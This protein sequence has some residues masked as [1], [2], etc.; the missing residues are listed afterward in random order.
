MSDMSDFIGVPQVQKK[1][2]RQ[3][4]GFC[5]PFFAEVYARFS[6]VVIEDAPLVNAAVIGG[7]H[8]TE[9]GGDIG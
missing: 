2:G 5:P 9:P 4:I 7:M 1:R 8:Q 6:V 3:N